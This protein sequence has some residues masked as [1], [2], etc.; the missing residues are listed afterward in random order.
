MTAFMAE[1]KLNIRHRICDGFAVGYNI[2]FPAI[3]IGLLGVLCRN[4]SHG[5]ISSY[6]YYSIVTIPFCIVMALITAAYAGKDD[7]YAKTA[8]RVLLSP[9][10]KGSIVAAKILSCT[11]VIFFSSIVTY[12]G[13]ALLTG[14]GMTGVGWIS[15][16]FL[17]ISFV[18]AALGICIGLGMK[19]FL[20]VKNIINLPICLF[21]IMGGAF[22]P[23]GTLHPTEAAVM[24]LS[25]LRWIN[26]SIFLMLYDGQSILIV[27]ICIILLIVGILCSLLA[28]TVFKK[29]E[30]C[31][32]SLPGYEE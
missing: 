16:L 23:L 28:V 12:I 5:G 21:G 1:L 22:F 6:Q 26:K 19:N 7:A 31:N 4:F 13:A 18:T 20:V 32:G 25:P 30:Y 27:R 14:I 15:Y 11:L 10:S 3:M 9:I 8:E 24:N 17:M 29:E 2:L